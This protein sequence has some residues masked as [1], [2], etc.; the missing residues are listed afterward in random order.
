MSTC[1]M[2]T[3]A[4]RG[5]GDLVDPISINVTA[6]K[7]EVQSKHTIVSFFAGCGGMDLGFL[8]GFDFKGS[9]IGDL[10]FNIISAY[11]FDEKCVETYS[12]NI[13]CH[14]AVRDLG[15]VSS[16]TMPSADILIGGFPCQ[17]FSICGPRVGLSSERGKL[18]E[19]LVD[20]M[21]LHKPKIV[22]AENVPHIARINGGAVMETIL[23]DL[24]SAGYR[25]ELWSLFA[26][27]YGV[28]QTRSRL[29]FIGVRD[30]IK[31]HPIKPVPT[32]N[33]NHMSVDWAIKDLEHITNDE[34][35]NQDQYFKA[36]KAKNGGGQGDEAC[37]VGQPSYTIRANSHSR[38]QFHYKLPRRL[39]VRECARLQ[40]F[41]DNFIFT[42]ST[43]TNM[44]QIGN[45]VPPL[46][47]NHV[48]KSI[49]IFLKKPCKVEKK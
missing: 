37:K 29:F 26:P 44:K 11:D 38:I 15:E 48:A 39:T 20:Y 33:D 45:A 16:A 47:A 30:D 4:Y 10:P 46:L 3:K 7:S 13:G 1:E 40:T 49:A 5:A 22:V 43:T 9:T 24:S 42:F 41:P 27:D 28:P 35:P 2:V 36:T 31:G 34:V 8:G 17:D 23:K 19:A 32:H 25:F 6:K 21:K 18:Y 12:A 14:A